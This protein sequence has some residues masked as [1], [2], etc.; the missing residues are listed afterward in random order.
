MYANEEI[1]NKSLGKSIT[2]RDGLNMNKVVGTFTG[3]KI[4][5]TFF[6]GTKTIDAV[7]ATPKLVVIVEFVIPEGYGVGDHLF[8]VLHFLSSSLI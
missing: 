7:W 5:A 8:F 1:Y 6:R 3:K 2:A 4:R